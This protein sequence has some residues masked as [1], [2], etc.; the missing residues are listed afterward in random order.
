L[1]DILGIAAPPSFR[2]RSL[3]PQMLG[4][5]DGPKPPIYAESL[6]FELEDPKGIARFTA[7]D[8][9]YRYRLE[10]VKRGDVLAR[11]ERLVDTQRE[12]GRRDVLLD[13]ELSQEHADSL[14]ALRS[15]VRRERARA[16]DP[17][18]IELSAADEARLR[19]LGYLGAEPVPVTPPSNPGR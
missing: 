14:E 19:A 2:G 8:D 12:A 7:R 4:A 1:L 13:A 10:E 15:V 11:S 5:A 9:R 3:L 18:S 6:Y 16:R 17:L